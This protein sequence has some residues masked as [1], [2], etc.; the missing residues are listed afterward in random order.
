MNGAEFLQTWWVLLS[1]QLRFFLLHYSYTGG[2]CPRIR[3]QALDTLERDVQRNDR[4][5]LATAECYF[6]NESSD[7]LLVLDRV[8]ERRCM[9]EL[10]LEL[11]LRSSSLRLPGLQL[12]CQHAYEI[13]TDHEELCSSLSTIVI[14]SKLFSQSVPYGAARNV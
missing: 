4:E 2:G 5:V 7:V 12:G 8:Q 10:E 14:N 11:R 1:S 9:M 13:E 6:K 3:K